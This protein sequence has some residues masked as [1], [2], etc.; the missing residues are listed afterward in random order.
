MYV[1]AEAWESLPKEYQAILEAARAEAHV[2]MQA[3]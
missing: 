2:D 1:N 3:K